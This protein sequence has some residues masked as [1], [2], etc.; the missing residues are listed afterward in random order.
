MPI[1]RD[2]NKLSIYLALFLVSIPNC[3]SAEYIEPL[4]RSKVYGCNLRSQVVKVK[5]GVQSILT[6]KEARRLKARLELGSD[7]N[8][9][10][11]RKIGRCLKGS[12]PFSNPCSAAAPSANNNEFHTQEIDG[13]ICDEEGSGVLELKDSQGRYCSATLVSSRIVITAAHCLTDGPGNDFP[14]TEIRQSTNFGVSTGNYGFHFDYFQRSR[15]EE[16]DIGY[17][18][19]DNAMAGSGSIPVL[20]STESVVVGEKGIALGY[21]QDENGQHGDLQAGFFKITAVDEIGFTASFQG[22]P[23]ETG[24]C[25]GDSG[26]PLLV[27]RA[28]RWYLAGVNSNI[29]SQDCRPPSSIYFASVKYSSK[30]CFLYDATCAFF[31]LIGGEVC[32][33]ECLP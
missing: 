13:R 22:L 21:G 19:L 17:V 7:S 33:F 32:P 4:A 29:S 26:G 16:R 15:E 9:R 8:K 23:G 28:N 20:P 5:N 24:L 14:P 1:Q 25:F 2:M 12:L 27:E 6:K 30:A 11:A 31:N 10:L 18:I 3:G